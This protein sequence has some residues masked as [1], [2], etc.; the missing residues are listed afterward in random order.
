M[1]LKIRS[2][3]PRTALLGAALLIGTLAASAASAAGCDVVSYRLWQP[4]GVSWYG[5]GET[6]EIG[7]GEEGHIYVHV[8]SR[9]KSPYTT[10]AEIGYPSSF[11][12][13]GDARRVAS[14][15]RM[16]AQNSSDRQAGRIRLRAQKPGTTSLGYRLKGVS[17]PGRLDAVPPRC[18]TGQIRIEVLGSSSGGDGGGRPQ[19]G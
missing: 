18:R 10:Q 2:C 15:V 5:V 6:I 19:P 8:D 12:F 16:E 1:T 4:N 7:A 17:S 11:G 3:S 14:M 9:S 13:G